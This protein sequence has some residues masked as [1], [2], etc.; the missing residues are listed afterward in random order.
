MLA[1]CKVKK[2]DKGGYHIFLNDVDIAPYALSFNLSMSPL[3]I[4][5]AKVELL[6]ESFECEELCKVFP[7]VRNL[8]GGR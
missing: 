2:N 3:G 4:P 6:L 5:V 7:E 8:K 1:K